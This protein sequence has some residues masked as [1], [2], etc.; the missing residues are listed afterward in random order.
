MLFCEAENGK[1]L[2]EEGGEKERKIENY[3]DC[4]V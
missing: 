1:M 2:K 3:N 4:K